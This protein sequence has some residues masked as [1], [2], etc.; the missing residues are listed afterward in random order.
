MAAKNLRDELLNEAIKRPKESPKNLNYS[1]SVIKA[2]LEGDDLKTA[3]KRNEKSLQPHPHSYAWGFD[4][5]SKLITDL[6]YEEVGLV[7]GHI[8]GKAVNSEFISYTDGVVESDAT[9]RWKVIHEMA[10]KE[11]GPPPNL[12]PKSLVAWEWSVL[13]KQREVEKALGFVVSEELIAKDSNSVMQDVVYRALTGNIPKAHEF[14]FIPY[15]SLAPLEYAM[16]VVEE[17][18]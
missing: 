16:S 9:S 8:S 10:H 5:P 1:L 12:N 6:C 11:V 17:F 3:F 15:E 2:V 18:A 4:Y 14:G 7:F 13:E